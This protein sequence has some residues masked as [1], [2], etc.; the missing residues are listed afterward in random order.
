M[1]WFQLVRMGVVPNVRNEFPADRDVVLVTG[2][3]WSGTV[4]PHFV[5]L[6]RATDLMPNTNTDCLLHL[7]FQRLEGF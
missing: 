5:R 4:K 2:S 3:L 6:D 7:A 1:W